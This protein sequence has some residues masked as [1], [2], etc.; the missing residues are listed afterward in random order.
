MI[1]E[2]E[3]GR[4]I[5]KVSEEMQK[6]GDI[7]PPEWAAFVKTGV[8]KERR[9]QQ[10]NWWY[11]RSAS[12]LR[13]IALSSP[14]GVSKLRRIYGGRKS[15][16]HKSEHKYPGSGAVIRKICQQLESAGLV[17]SDKK[18]GRRLTPKGND[19]LKKVAKSIKNQH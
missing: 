19:F 8:S 15:R 3:A 14:L 16:G 5:E 18:N 10:D 2:T 1:K 6:I 12:I 4:L 11:I 17:R 7:K 13:K 9:P